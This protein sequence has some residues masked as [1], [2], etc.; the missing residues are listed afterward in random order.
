MTAI[1]PAN[2][3]VREA[4]QT[5][6]PYE[7]GKPV[8]E[9]RRELGL[10]TI[11]KLASN[12][13][14]FGP[15]PAALNAIKAGIGEL[16]RYPDGGIYRLRNALATRHG[17][18]QDNVA[19][20]AGAD[21]IISYLLLALLEPGD[22]V[23]CGWPSFP[24][25]VIDARK[26][27]ATAV[28]VPLRDGF[29]DLPAL[30]GAI[31]DR[32]RV[33]FICNPN[34]PTGTMVDRQAVDA[35]FSDVPSHVLTVLDE[36][37]WEYVDDQGYPD[38]IAEYARDGHATLVLRTFSKIFGLAGLRVGYGVG[39]SDVVAAVRKVQNAF[40]VTQPA[41][42]A[43]L[44]S[45]GDVAELERRRE[46]NRVGRDQLNGGLLQL[47]LK[48]IEPAVANFVYVDLGMD[49]RSI[50]DQMLRKGVI[51][52]PMA[53]FGAE[54]AVRISVGTAEDND[55]CLGALGEVLTSGGTS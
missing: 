32:T 53:A 52:R 12:E 34:N 18:E 11:V 26:L 27:S 20:G 49:G 28:L 29:Y 15:F 47:G 23:V 45:L 37:Y 1:G 31:T 8:D 5:L 51:I 25:Y 19:V 14:P 10:D 22:E 35:Y 43:A 38:G 46:L 41:Q 17:V 4:V 30:L 36:A 44:A 33:V 2:I 7:P 13:G 24:S 3:R 6:V 9:V 42:D 50:A 48:P 40:D 55:V 16:N 54:S 21:A 39:P